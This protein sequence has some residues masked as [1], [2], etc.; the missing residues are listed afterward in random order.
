M[1]M[2]TMGPKPLTYR[3]RLSGESAELSVFGATH[4]ADPN[5]P[6]F[7]EIEAC[8]QESSAALML[9]EGVPDLLITSSQ[10]SSVPYLDEVGGLSRTEAITSNGEAS[11]GI[12]L[13]MQKGIPVYCPE[14]SFQK[15]F[16]TLLAMGYR[17]EELFAEYVLQGLFQFVRER[18]GDI[19]EHMKANIRQ[20]Y[21]ISPWNN[22]RPSVEEFWS[23][24][25]G[26][27]P[28]IKRDNI[29]RDVLW[30]TLSPY[31]Q[32]QSPYYCRITEISR[33]AAVTRDRH[34][35]KQILSFTRLA[36]SVFVIYG[37]SHVEEWESFLRQE[38]P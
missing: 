24:L 10:L 2:L 11:F 7:D 15:L 36:D 13:A 28:C 3:Y 35:E 20:F 8:F 29:E 12:W 26:L 33:N 17:R 27:A 30:R 23:I 31:T 4:T 37:R 25:E 1:S 6:M 34:I 21:Q 5:H 22:Y 9:V 16:S 14:P 32:A 38:F 18:P 19:E